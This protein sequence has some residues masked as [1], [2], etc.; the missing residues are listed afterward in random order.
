MEWELMLWLLSFFSVA[1]ALG[2]VIYQLMCLSDLEL[3]YINPFDSASSINKF[4]LPE[5]IIQG[6]LAGLYLLTGHWIMV[7][8]NAP[9]TYYNVNLFLKRQHLV[10]VTEIFNV[11]GKEKKHRL[12][13]LG[14]YVL[15]FFIVI[16][17]LVYTAVVS[18]IEGDNVGSHVES[19]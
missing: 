2:F 10:D 1:A 6:S 16:Y 4:V 11:L 14:F 12:I 15:M 19:F 9:M 17:R 13:K 3:D 5:F 7:L 18:I 8:I